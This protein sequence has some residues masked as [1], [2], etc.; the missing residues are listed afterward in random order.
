MSGRKGP[1][2]AKRLA[3][4]KRLRRFE[5]VIALL[6]LGVAVGYA[7]G[8]SKDAA[9]TGP[10]SSVATVRPSDESGTPTDSPT[11]TSQPS[12]GA[13][14]ET[15]V[16]QVNGATSPA[17]AVIGAG[18]S[19]KPSSF[20][21]IP[22]GITLLDPSRGESSLAAV[23]QLPPGQMRVAISNLTGVWGKHFAV[24][25]VGKLGQAIDRGGEIPVDL[26]VSIRVSSGYIGPG[27]VQLSGGDIAD[28]LSSVDATYSDQLFTA[29]VSGLL[30]SPPVFQSSDLVASD[31]LTSVNAVL[32]GAESAMGL[33]LKSK[34][35]AAGTLVPDFEGID[36]VVAQSFGNRRPVT[37]SLEDANW[38]ASVGNAAAAWMVPAG[39]RVIGYEKTSAQQ[40]TTEVQ[41]GD[42]ADR[43]QAVRLQTVLR[44][45]DVTVEPIPSGMAQ[46]AVS[47]GTDFTG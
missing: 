31:D 21:T 26:P 2:R 17:I 30:T 3:R 6:V 4:K 47:L 19:S 13:I 12:P 41:A 1:S 36:T 45:G 42:E 40:G 29:V 35:N 44:V 25:D 16:L 23:A 38:T 37:V 11:P 22:G 18:T 10:T 24:T 34:R 32:S 9:R 28:L 43:Q 39:Y 7:V 20:V 14:S 5:I 46:I 27:V 8:Q 15:L 33:V